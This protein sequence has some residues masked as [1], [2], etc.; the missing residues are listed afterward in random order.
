MSFGLGFSLVSPKSKRGISGAVWPVEFSG[1]LC[2]AAAS[3]VPSALMD[4]DFLDLVEEEDDAA[5]AGA[6]KADIN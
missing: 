1:R 2:A 6:S 4:A 5:G 3:R